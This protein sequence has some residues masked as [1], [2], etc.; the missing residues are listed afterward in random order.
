[1]LTVLFS[2]GFIDCKG[3]IKLTLMNWWVDHEDIW[4]P[5]E[6]R[7]KIPVNTNLLVSYQL[8]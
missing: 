1:M 2:P 3:N 8:V 6:M 5:G 4:E 7:E